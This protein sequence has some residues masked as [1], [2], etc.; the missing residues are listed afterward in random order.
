MLAD[1]QVGFVVKQPVEDVGRVPHA[2]VD[3]LSAEERVLIGDV[4]IE[5][6]AQ[7]G[8]VLRVDWPVLSA[9]PPAL[10]R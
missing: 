9:L 6:L 4:G 10:K 7:L 2:D 5:E 8:S 1:P 3:N